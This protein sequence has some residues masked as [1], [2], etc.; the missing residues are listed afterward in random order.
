MLKNQAGVS[1]VEFVVGALLM[2]G[3]SLVITQNFLNQKSTENTNQRNLALESSIKVVSDALKNRSVCE[4]FLNQFE[5]SDLA[6]AEGYKVDS[7]ISAEEGSSNTVGIIM[8]QL[9]SKA[10]VRTELESLNIKLGGSSGKVPLTIKFNFLESL[11]NGET[12]DLYRTIE[13]KVEVKDSVIICGGYNADDVDTVAFE[14]AC[15]SIG[16][17]VNG[18]ECEVTQINTDLRSN[19]KKWLCNILN[20]SG[21]ESFDAEGRC[22]TFSV[23]QT[24]STENIA[25][26]KLMING[27]TRTK[28]ENTRC[29]GY[30]TGFSV[31]GDKTCSEIIANFQ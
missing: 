3:L 5:I 30:L 12:K 19:M 26:N 22:S 11:A 29:T 15:S 1:I 24:L 18:D 2:G 13:Q 21:A 27:Q 17:S 14:R 9:G 10:D 23:S 4:E 8:N 28:F 6:T 20:S 16:G 31:A 7:S 25:P